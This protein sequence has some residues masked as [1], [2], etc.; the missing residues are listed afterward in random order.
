MTA[1]SGW[2]LICVVGLL[3]WGGF[4][5]L[6]RKSTTSHALTTGDSGHDSN[7][8]SIS[9][10]N[11]KKDDHGDKGH[12]KWPKLETIGTTLGVIF[13]LILIAW[14]GMSAVRS[15]LTPAQAAV[16]PPSVATR[17]VTTDPTPDEIRQK[18]LENRQ[19]IE[20]EDHSQTLT[21]GESM[22]WVRVPDG[23]FVTKLEDLPD[24]KVVGQQC[25]LTTQKPPADA[26]GIEYDCLDGITA[27]WV[28]FSVWSPE[29]GPITAHWHFHY[30][31]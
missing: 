13:L 12:S 1:I 27:H 30:A 16:R 15:A 21:Y 18:V 7:V 29:E 17:L 6:R 25:S 14:A 20:S 28:R 2:L 11:H 3:V 19:L 10:N 23:G 8:V 24:G 26:K 5:L 9:I 4:V 31:F 22:D